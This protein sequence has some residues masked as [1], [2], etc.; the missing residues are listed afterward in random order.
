MKSMMHLS[1]WTNP[2]ER[3]LLPYVVSFTLER[4]RPVPSM[5][6]EGV[7]YHH[8][9]TTLEA[10]VWAENKDSIEEVLQYH[11]PNRWRYNRSGGPDSDCLILSSDLRPVSRTP[12]RERAGGNGG[13]R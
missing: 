7:I 12:K 10:I 4:S 1:K 8:P 3:G 13:T 5:L 11:Y 9:E 2:Q 6:D